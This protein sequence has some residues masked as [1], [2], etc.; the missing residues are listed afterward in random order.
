MKLPVHTSDLQ[1]NGNYNSSQ[2]FTFVDKF[3]CIIN[4]NR[5]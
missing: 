3:D 4:F 1:N 2:A 5:N